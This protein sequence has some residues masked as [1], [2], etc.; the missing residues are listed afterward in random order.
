MNDLLRQQLQNLPDATP[1]VAL[2]ERLADAR[3]QQ[4]RRQRRVIAG[5]TAACAALAATLLF[6]LDPRLGDGESAPVTANTITPA[7]TTPVASIASHESLHHIDRELQL[8]YARNADDAELASLWAVRQGLLHSRTD[9]VQ[10]LG[11]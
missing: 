4:V 2:W 9:N 3:Q 6:N 11:I 8:A 10:P 5:G 1:S 7:P